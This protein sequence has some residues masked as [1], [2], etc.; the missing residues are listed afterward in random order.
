[1]GQ[2]SDC[3]AETCGGRVPIVDLTRKLLR[4]VTRKDLLAVGARR[5][6]E[7]PADAVHPRLTRKAG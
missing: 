6:A 7:D 1:M 5:V 3:M 2:L 4:P